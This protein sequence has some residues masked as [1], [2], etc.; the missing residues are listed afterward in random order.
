MAEKHYL[1]VIPLR[2]GV[3]FPGMTTTITIGRAR[4]LAAAQAAGQGDGEILILVQYDADVEEPET[5]DLAPIGVLA[6]VRDVM[7]TPHIGVQM[8]V[9]LHRRVR[10]EGLTQTQ[11]Y[12][13]GGYSEIEALEESEEDGQ[14]ASAELIAY[15]EQYAEALGEVNRQVM[16]ALRNQTSAGE[17]ADYAAGLLNL[18]F[19]LEL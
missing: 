16:M 9:E 12:M 8:L 18:P 5:S 14:T 17:L 19:D 1:P 7:R 15:L 4:S 13:M 11:P 3:V 2:G 10:F 6:T